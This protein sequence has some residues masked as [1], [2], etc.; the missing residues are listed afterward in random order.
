MV[1]MATGVQNEIFQ[2]EAN[3]CPFIRFDFSNLADSF[4]A[5]RNLPLTG[6]VHHSRPSSLRS[7]GV[8]EMKLKYE[9][10]EGSQNYLKKVPVGIC[11]AG[12]RRARKVFAD[13]TSRCATTSATASK[14]P[15]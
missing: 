8:P 3:C 15:I 4:S 10:K 5:T 6:F 14:T 2:N 11:R 9:A 13:E 7:R 12:N 1:D